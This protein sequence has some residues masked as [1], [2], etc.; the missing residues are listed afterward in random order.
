MWLDALTN[1]PLLPGRVLP[2]NYLGPQSF[3][4]VRQDRWRVEALRDAR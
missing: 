4:A 1:D 3:V 2:S